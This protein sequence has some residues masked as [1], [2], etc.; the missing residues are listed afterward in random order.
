LAQGVRRGAG[1]RV[2]MREREWCGMV[3]DYGQKPQP[4]R[5]APRSGP[6]TT[7]S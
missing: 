4:P 6:L 1:F 3:C 7:P 2:Q 5:S